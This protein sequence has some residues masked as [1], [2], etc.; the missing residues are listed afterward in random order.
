MNKS[1]VRNATSSA[2]DTFYRIRLYVITVVPTQLPAYPAAAL[3]TI[4]LPT[5]Q[6]ITT[7]CGVGSDSEHGG[8]Q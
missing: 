1:S 6:F 3:P 4:L 7:Y 5:C 2:S 8:I